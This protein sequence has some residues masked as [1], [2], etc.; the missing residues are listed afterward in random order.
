MKERPMIFNAEMVRAILDGRKTQTRRIVK[1]VPSSHNFH[2]WVMS[3]TSAKDE[4]KAC[5]AVGKSP[6]LNH[7][8]RMR[9]PFGEVGD[10]IWVRE[11][12]AD[13]NHAGCPAVAYRAD[14][15]VRD[16]NE[17]DGDE[18]DPNLEKYCFANWYPDLISGTEG[19]WTP[20]IHMPRWASRI[21]LEITGVRVERLASI[22]TGDAQAKGYPAERAEN[23]GNLDAWLWFRDLWDGI[24][25]EQTLKHNPWV[26]VIEFK[27]IEGGA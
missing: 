21:T 17:E 1:G 15:E 14:S 11:T 4:G 3:S 5:W 26:W 9:C 23:G 10:R 27:R 8:I 16:L 12:W 20:S 6:L 7:P 19:N 25:P 22:S 13:V 18:Q 24:Y 2:G